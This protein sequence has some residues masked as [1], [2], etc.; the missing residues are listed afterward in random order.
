MRLQTNETVWI[1]AILGRPREVKRS[2]S[3]DALTHPEIQSF[4]C[5]YTVYN[6]TLMTDYK[7]A[8]FSFRSLRP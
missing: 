3:S 8:W 2:S 4:L 1:K 5:V 6:L 7:Q